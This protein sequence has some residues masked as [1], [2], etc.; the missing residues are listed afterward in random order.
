MRGA[1]LM[2]EASPLPIAITPP[3][4]HVKVNLSIWP[5]G[6]LAQRE[7]ICANHTHID[8]I[9]LSPSVCLSFSPS[10]SPSLA[11]SPSLPISSHCLSRS[12]SV[13]LSVLLSMI[14]CLSACLPL[15]LS[16]FLSIYPS[17][18]LSLAHAAWCGVVRCGAVWCVSDVCKCS[19]WCPG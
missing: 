3:P 17:I 5:Q 11:L 12:C 6:S 9:C 19:V 14:I 18:S 8:S 10:P 2:G 16:I 4:S 1:L 13:C 15:F 7:P